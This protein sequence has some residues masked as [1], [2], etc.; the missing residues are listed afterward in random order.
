MAKIKA[1][2]K[3]KAYLEAENEW[4]AYHH[5]YIEKETRGYEFKQYD[6]NGQLVAMLSGYVPKKCKRPKHPKE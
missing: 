1:S 2:K 3:T 6:K 5:F 4:L